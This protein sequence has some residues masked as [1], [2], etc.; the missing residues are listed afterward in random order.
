VAG[1]EEVADFALEWAVEH[2]TAGASVH[3]QS[4]DGMPAP[5]VTGA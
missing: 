4:V 1:W 2:G 3:E 5:T